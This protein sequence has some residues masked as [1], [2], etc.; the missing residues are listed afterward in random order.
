M[1]HS[2]FMIAKIERAGALDRMDSILETA[3]G[4]MTARGDLG[5]EIPIEQ[6]AVVQKRLMQ[7]VNLLGK[8]VIT[9][10]QMLESM[11]TYRRPTRAEAMEWRRSFQKSLDRGHNPTRNT[12]DLYLMT[13]P[14]EEFYGNQ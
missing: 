7:Q 6:I 5:V 3:D 8:P 12:L 9:A 2:P 4:I 13:Y 1:G 14:K 11:T 10:T